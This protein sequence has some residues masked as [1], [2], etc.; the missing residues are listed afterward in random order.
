MAI[1]IAVGTSIF[2]Y[3]MGLQDQYAALSSLQHSMVGES[4]AVQ[5][6]LE[7]IARVAPLDS[8]VLITGERGS[9][10]K[11][12]ARVLHDNGPRAQKPFVAVICAAVGESLLESVLL[13]QEAGP[14]AVASKG[15]LELAEGGT[16]Y[17]STKSV[18][19]LS[20]LQS[21]SL[22]RLLQEK[23]FERVDG[24][25]HAPRQPVPHRVQQP[26]PGRC[27]GSRDFSCR[28]STIDCVCCR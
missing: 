27:R 12:V 11:T 15:K 5:H 18:K 13:G 23:K 2:V 6:V 3:L 9:G 20:P 10:K 22:L 25:P 24:R 21:S 17:S 14:G 19:W 4:P 28:I 26:R 1:E 16:V 8:T 7:F